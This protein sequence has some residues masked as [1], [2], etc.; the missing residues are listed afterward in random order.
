MHTRDPLNLRSLP[1][2]DPPVDAWGQIERRLQRKPRSPWIWA[3]AATL[4]I[5]LV[6]GALLTSGDGPQAGQ[7]GAGDPE[8]DRWIAYSQVL[9]QQ[10]RQVR[11]RT[12]SYRAHQGIAVAELED[13]VAAID[14]GLATTDSEQTR[15]ALWQ[16]RAL[17]LDDLVAIY[18]MGRMAGEGSGQPVPIVTRVPVTLASNSL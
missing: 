13:M 15:L 10:L 1:Q 5:G 3:A 8:I 12:A 2:L 9:E 18:A 17:V 6:T 4:A 11:G 7:P 14:A 16:Q